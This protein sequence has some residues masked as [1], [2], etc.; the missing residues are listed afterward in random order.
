MATLSS[1]CFLASG[2]KKLTGI[3]SLDEGGA[4]KSFKLIAFIA[5]Q[6]LAIHLLDAGK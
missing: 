2:S 3:R 1:L 5:L 4:F 6:F